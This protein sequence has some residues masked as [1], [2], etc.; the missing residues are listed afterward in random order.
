MI[1]TF[2]HVRGEKR[3][4]IADMISYGYSSETIV[5]EIENCDVVCFNCHSLREQER[6]KAYPWRM[7]K[8]R[9]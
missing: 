4:N 9:S 2:D 5:T 3:A 8:E 7:H 6:S 1:L